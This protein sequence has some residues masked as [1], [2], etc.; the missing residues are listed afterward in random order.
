MSVVFI[1]L[2]FSRKLFSVYK[3]L[4]NSFMCVCVCIPKVTCIVGTHTSIKIRSS[5]YTE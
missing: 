2:M 1:T 3:Y 4:N 5:C